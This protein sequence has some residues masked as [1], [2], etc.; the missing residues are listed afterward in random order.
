[1]V[2]RYASTGT[3]RGLGGGGVDRCG[4]AG[5]MAIGSRRIVEDEKRVGVGGNSGAGNPE[6][7]SF[8]ALNGEVLDR[9][10]LKVRLEVA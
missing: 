10:E 6:D 9:V 3:G 8:V 4:T 7:E 5:C 2:G 1:M